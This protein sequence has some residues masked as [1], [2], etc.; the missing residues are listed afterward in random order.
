[1]MELLP[2]LVL[3]V[4]GIGVYAFNRL[5]KG[6]GESTDSE[7]QPYD[8]FPPKEPVE[9]PRKAPAK[10]ASTKKKATKKKTTKKKSSGKKSGGRKPKMTIAE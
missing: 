3:V 8:P 1:M 9:Q 5:R 7:S 4:L 2:I 10:K 6:S